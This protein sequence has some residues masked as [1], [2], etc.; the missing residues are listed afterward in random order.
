M[1]VRQGTTKNFTRIP[2]EITRSGRTVSAIAYRVYGVI[3]SFHPSYP[4]FSALE[5]YTGVSRKSVSRALKELSE[6]GIITIL[7]RGT[8]RG[9]TNE[10]RVNAPEQWRLPSV[11]GNLGAVGNQGNEE[12]SPSVQSPPD[13]GDE[14]NQCTDQTWFP[15]ETGSGVPSTPDLVADV[16]HNNINYG[17]SNN[18]TNTSNGVLVGGDSH[19]TGTPSSL[20]GDT[21]PADAFDFEALYAIF[22]KRGK[23]TKK[24]LGMEKCRAQI[25]TQEQYEKLKS[26]V[27]NYIEHIKEQKRKRFDFE[28]SFIKS[29]G[30]FM[31]KNYWVDFINVNGHTKKEI[32]ICGRDESCKPNEDSIL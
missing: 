21:P 5:K 31:T 7:S 8:F 13:L 26:A 11:A 29:W 1:S 28:D 25:K 20:N 17:I 19:H 14:G 22:P 4:S 6:L 27:L 15:G 9:N 2:N 30:H 12:T 32:I 18:K 24:S 10:Y 16:P 23:D 3:A